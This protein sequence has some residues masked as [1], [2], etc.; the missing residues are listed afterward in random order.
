LSVAWSS[1][2]LITLRRSLSLLG[3]TIFG[4]HIGLRFKLNQQVRLLVW[5]LGICAVSSLAACLLFP[6]YGIE[7]EV[8]GYAWRGVFGHKNELGR[9]G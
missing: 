9:I 5:A 6:S 1:I 7:S 4:V 8:Y 2:P 3:S